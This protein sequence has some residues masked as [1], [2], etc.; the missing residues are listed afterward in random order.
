MMLLRSMM[1]VAG[2]GSSYSGIPFRRR[3][4]DLEAGLVQFLQV[5]RQPERDAELPGDR[6]RMI[7]EHLERHAVLLGGRGVFGE[8]PGRGDH[9]DPG[10]GDLRQLRV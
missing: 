8:P 6:V 2:I 7:A 4:I 5:W 9:G 10:R 3:Q 1:K